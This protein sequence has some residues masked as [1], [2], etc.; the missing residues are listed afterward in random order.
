M[1]LALA[2]TANIASPQTQIETVLEYQRTGNK[3]LLAKLIES[4]VRLVMKIAKS[5]VRHNCSNG[6]GHGFKSMCKRTAASLRLVGV[7]FVLCSNPSPVLC[8]S[9]VST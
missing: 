9:M 7:P 3:A 5:Y 8:V 1:L 2:Q 6:L 4:N